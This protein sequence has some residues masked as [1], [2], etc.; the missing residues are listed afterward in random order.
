MNAE[1]W[2]YVAVIVA[3]G[4][5][6]FWNTRKSRFDSPEYQRRSRIASLVEL[7][8]S[9]IVQTVISADG[10]TAIQ[11]ELADL[12]VADGFEVASRWEKGQS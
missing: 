10:Y 7:A 4:L 12:L 8:D 3:F 9:E 2:V 6:T 11:Q 1:S 5:W